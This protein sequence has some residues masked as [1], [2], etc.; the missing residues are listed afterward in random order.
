MFSPGS[1][2]SARPRYCSL[3]FA[4]TRTFQ[5]AQNFTR[6]RIHRRKFARRYL[7]IRSHETNLSP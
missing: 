7:K 4:F 6:R 3:D 2:P 5:F 1:L